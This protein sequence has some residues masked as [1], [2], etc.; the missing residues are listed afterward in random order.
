MLVQHLL[1]NFTSNFI[2]NGTAPRATPGD[3]PAHP[4]ERNDLLVFLR[5][6]ENLLLL[7]SIQ[8]LSSQVSVLIRAH[9]WLVGG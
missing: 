2:D 9:V 4:M 5:Q 8:R 6:E 1:A 7:G 3:D